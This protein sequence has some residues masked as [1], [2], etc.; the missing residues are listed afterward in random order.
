M[1]LANV[2]F[3]LEQQAEIDAIVRERMGA[4][5]FA[6]RTAAE[7]ARADAASAR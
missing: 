7:V 6:A 5:G 2:T 4:A 3:T 1:P